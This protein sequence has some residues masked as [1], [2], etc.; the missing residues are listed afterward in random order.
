[1][2]VCVR[3]HKGLLVMIDEYRRREYL[4]LRVS[5]RTDMNLFVQTETVSCQHHDSNVSSQ[6]A[7]PCCSTSIAAQSVFRARA[8]CP[9]KS[10]TAR[11]AVSIVDCI[12]LACVLQLVNV[13]VSRITRRIDSTGGPTG[14]RAVDPF[15]GAGTTLVAEVRGNKKTESLTANVTRFLIGCMKKD[16]SWGA[17]LLRRYGDTG[18]LPVV[19]SARFWSVLQAAEYF[20]LRQR[21]VW[22][23]ADTYKITKRDLQMGKTLEYARE[24]R[25][26]NEF[27]WELQSIELGAFHRPF[28]G[29]AANTD[30]QAQAA[31]VKIIVEKHK[32]L[33]DL[34]RP[35]IGPPLQDGAIEA[36]RAAKAAAR[37]A[38]FVA[39]ARPLR[40]RRR[41]FEE[42]CERRCVLGRFEGIGDDG[43]PML[44]VC[45]AAERA[46][47]AAEIEVRS[48]E[49]LNDPG[50][51][52]ALNQPPP[53]KCDDRLQAMH[54]AI[55]N[56]LQ[57]MLTDIAE[58]GKVSQVVEDA[59]TPNTSFLA[60]D[61][62][63][64]TRM[65][66]LR[67][68]WITNGLIDAMRRVSKASVAFRLSGG[69][70]AWWSE[71]LTLEDISVRARNIR[72]KVWVGKAG[73]ADL[74]SAA[75]DRAEHVARAK[76]DLR[77]DKQDQRT[78]ET[79]ETSG[80]MLAAD[81][82]D[83]RCGEDGRL[84]AGLYLTS[85]EF[86][87]IKRKTWGT[88][89]RKGFG[90]KEKP[91]TT[92]NFWT[93]TALTNQLRLRNDPAWVDK[94]QRDCTSLGYNGAMH[95]NTWAS[96]LQQNG[97]LKVSGTRGVTLGLLEKVLDLEKLV[98]S[99]MKAAER[100]VQ[101]RASRAQAQATAATSA[102][103]PAPALEPRSL[104]ANRGVAAP[105]TASAAV[106]QVQRSTV[107]AAVQ[108][109]RFTRQ[110]TE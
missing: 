70:P 51:M 54:H 98:D 79:N 26:L 25:A 41:I 8:P 105:G 58:T 12:T 56:K 42:D 78:E 14:G 29:A 91:T 18:G 52:A 43:A 32:A 59:N 1:M 103:P 53:A 15:C 66:H 37:A 99:A 2:C 61:C 109:P 71:W 44:G 65:L 81:K 16:Q 17:F 86:N 83:G 82:H 93:L 68:P 30:P 50:F 4:W 72:K 108:Q 19:K 3:C 33:L 89:G 87:A 97:T 28:N 57:Q 74:R 13:E 85:V 35:E 34:P 77:T 96:L 75:D 49:L 60:E 90:T 45:T 88:A 67:A 92:Y 100:Q 31:N 63:Q 39:E 107:P 36:D 94:L 38:Y 24:N 10:D 48:N 73:Q 47:T 6:Q 21:Y 110:R 102:A 55:V 7:S 40:L 104:R 9:L 5:L 46:R 22:E 27:S 69:L 80:G 101:Q 76:Q 20:Y 64:Y 62:F 11:W 23:F 84:C 106:Q 95:S